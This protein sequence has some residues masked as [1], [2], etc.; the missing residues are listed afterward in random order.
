MH[1]E[2]GDTALSQ[3]MNNTNVCTV[4]KLCRT[5]LDYSFSFLS[6][7]PQ[8][9]GVETWIGADYN[10]DTVT[11]RVSKSATTGAAL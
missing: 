11:R 4:S 3:G 5:I 8:V 9:P 2:D 10:V 7:G 1:V 6:V